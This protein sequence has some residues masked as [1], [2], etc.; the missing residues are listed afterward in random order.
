[1]SASNTDLHRSVSPLNKRRFRAKAFG[2]GKGLC[3]RDAALIEECA[4]LLSRVGY[5]LRGSTL[6]MERSTLTF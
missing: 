5:L 2:I 3:F 4:A 6:L 1:M